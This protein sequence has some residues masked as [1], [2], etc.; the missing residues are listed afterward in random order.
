VQEFPPIGGDPYYGSYNMAPVIEATRE[1]ATELLETHVRDIVPAGIPVKRVLLAGTPARGIEE[2]AD[3]LDADLVVLGT[4]GRGGLTRLLLGSVAER[5]LRLAERPTLIVRGEEG[6]VTEA[7]RLTQI[8]CPMNDSP[9]AMAAFHAAHTTARLFGAK[10]T[11]LTVVEEAGRAEAPGS[12]S[13]AV[14]ALRARLVQELGASAEEDLARCQFQAVAREGDAAEQ[15]IAQA[16]EDAVD[17]VILGAQHK[18]FFD[19]TVL[20]VTTD[21]VTRHAP[22][23]VLVVPLMPEGSA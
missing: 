5:A 18:R 13:R 21:R 1:A 12:L 2:A 17:L 4:R 3:E 11:V 14:E 22:C 20:G 10:L 19:S 9:V 23:P 8:L 16:R 6:E 15:V 7:P